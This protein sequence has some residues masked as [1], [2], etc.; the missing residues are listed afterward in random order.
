MEAYCTQGTPQGGVGSPHLWNL[1]ANDLI[2]RIKT[3]TG[4]KIV[5][6]ADDA[7]IWFSGPDPE[8]SVEIVQKAVDIAIE[9]GEQNSLK[10]SPSKTEA[11]VI[12]RKRK[13][14]IPLITKL[15]IGDRPVE[16][17]NQVRHLGV[18][19]DRKLSWGPHLNTKSAAC[20][21]QLYKWIGYQ[22]GMKGLQPLMASYIWRGII[23]P[24]LTFGCL[25]WSPVL[26]TK[27]RRDQIKSVQALSFRLLTFFRKGTPTRGLEMITHTMPIEIFVF[28]TAAK[29][30]IRTQSYQVFSDA[31][32]YTQ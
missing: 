17:A 11:M 2:Q 28:K 30:Y 15:K 3:E 26:R 1:V 27:T 22:Q 9:W 18:I 20:K 23:R 21:K 19:V 32:M 16:Y 31:E 5:M 25:V 10:F 4:A 7:C 12:S 24:K 8:K 13:L 29:A 6:Y 14:K